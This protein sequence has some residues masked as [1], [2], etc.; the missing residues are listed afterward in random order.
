MRRISIRHIRAG[1]KHQAERRFDLFFNPKNPRYGVR[2]RV[3]RTK[4]EMVTQYNSEVPPKIRIKSAGALC[5]CYGSPKAALI[6]DL[7][8][9]EGKL[10]PGIL[11]HEVFHAI[12]GYCRLH[13]VDLGKMLE[14]KSGIATKQEEWF[15][16]QLE[17]LVDQ[18]HAGFRKLNL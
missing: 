10:S 1:K 15:A 8:F 11:A 9:H 3:F 5:L 14:I 17:T 18:A 6:A 13:K 2:V 12:I 16:T 7:L 4:K